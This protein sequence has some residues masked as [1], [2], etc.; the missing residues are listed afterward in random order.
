ME[1]NKITPTFSQM[2]YLQSLGMNCD[3]ASMVYHPA[4]SHSK[5]F[6]LQ[7]TDIQHR[8]E[9]WND[10]KRKALVGDDYYDRMYGRDVPAYTADDLLRKIPESICINGIWHRLFIGKKH[11]ED[12]QIFAASYSFRD[13]NGRFVS[14]RLDAEWESTIFIQMLYKILLWCIDNKFITITE[15]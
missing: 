2:C 12:V 11:E 5:I 4:T 13:D 14:R 1:E 3:D 9:F 6:M 10:P 15:Q 7:V 8:R